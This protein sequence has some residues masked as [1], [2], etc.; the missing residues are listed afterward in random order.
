MACA[1]PLNRNSFVEQHIRSRRKFSNSLAKASN[2]H[3]TDSTNKKNREQ[4][5]HGRL[6]FGFGRPKERQVAQEQ[7]DT[8]QHDHNSIEATLNGLD[9]SC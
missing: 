9:I 1:R 6:F 4:E 7:Y 3:K 8:R 5:W 2:L